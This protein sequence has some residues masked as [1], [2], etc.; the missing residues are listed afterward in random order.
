MPV[1]IHR[2]A[3]RRAKLD[4]PFLILEL[5]HAEPDLAA[6]AM[7][8]A[9]QRL[10]SLDLAAADDFA[11]SQGDS[12]FAYI[13]EPVPTST[14]A[15]IT[16]DTDDLPASLLAR[17]PKA[18]AE[19][20]TAAGLSDGEVRV[21][22]VE[23]G[24]FNSA[25][26][27]V[28][29]V[30]RLHFVAAPWSPSQEIAWPWAGVA[31]A[32]LLGDGHDEV[33]VMD[34]GFQWSTDGRRFKSSL[35]RVAPLPSARTFVSGPMDGDFR[36]VGTFN[37]GSSSMMSLAYGSALGTAEITEEKFAKLRAIVREAAP[38]LVY[39]S[40]NFE[41]KPQRS[42]V[43][44][45]Y[46]AARRGRLADYPDITKVAPLLDRVVFDAFPYQLVSEGHINRLGR[47]DSPA[48]TRNVAPGR[49][50]ISFGSFSSWVTAPDPLWER[51][52]EIL[53]PC[54]VNNRQAVEMLREDFARRQTEFGR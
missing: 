23:G 4:Q 42:P 43:Y 49:W 24:P 34:G 14:G 20:V 12:T 35:Q 39:A 53:A 50:E 16:V 7:N 11:V 31:E 5:R 25:P 17:L 52:R 19:A 1:R 9:R 48:E 36:V 22:S 28:G 13:S 46:D 29:V 47:L 38:G 21:P 2:S 45:A 26:E 30:A 8:A 32:F 40:I 54:I 51:G 10:L 3:E 6:D 33:W 18:V 15:F 27:S 37:Y 41:Q 44:S